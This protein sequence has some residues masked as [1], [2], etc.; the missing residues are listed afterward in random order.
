M[1]LTA[2][3]RIA[4]ILGKTGTVR[5]VRKGRKNSRSGSH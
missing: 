4:E 5:I 2:R 3:D 1:P